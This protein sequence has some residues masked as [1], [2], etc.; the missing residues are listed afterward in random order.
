MAFSPDGQLLASGG[1]DRTVRLWNV[2]TGQQIGAALTGHNSSIASV[3]FTAD[4]R[5]VVSASGDATARIWPAI[6][7]PDM[8][9]D[10]L[11]TNMSQRQ[12]RDWVS[13]DPA[14]GYRGLCPDLPVV[15]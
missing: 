9:C 8:L 10:K 6:A 4:G 11:T 7:T 2:D 3:A 15:N 13:D 1:V 5:R 14:I 12:W